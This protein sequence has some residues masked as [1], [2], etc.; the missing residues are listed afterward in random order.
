[1]HAKGSSPHTVRSYYLGLKRLLAFVQEKCGQDAA[2][3]DVSAQSLEEFLHVLLDSGLS[4][5]TRRHF[6]YVLKS[7]FKYCRKMGHISSDPGVDLVPVSIP[8]VLPLYLEASQVHRFIDNCRDPL[9]RTLAT[10]LFYTGVRIGELCALRLDDV[11]AG[12][13]RLRVYGKGA[14]ERVVPL[15]GK[16][17]QALRWY[18]REVR[19]QVR[20]QALFVTKR[21]RELD[22]NWAGILIRREAERQGWQMKITPHTFRHS[23]ATAL[24]SHGV[25]LLTIAALLG[26]ASLTTTQVYTHLSTKDLLEAVNRLE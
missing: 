26:H 20:S 11:D 17:G 2:V 8:R 12:W 19:P 10:V 15:S 18:V 22:R 3:A 21:G 23:H 24:Y 5:R 7:F 14:K 9:V 6:V 4:P 1:M 16:A 25:G 13:S